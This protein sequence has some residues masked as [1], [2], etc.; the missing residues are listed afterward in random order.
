[1][2]AILFRIKDTGK[3]TL[4]MLFVFNP[5]L[6]FWSCYTLERPWLQNQIG[7]SCIP[8]GVYKCKM[9]HSP[10]FQKMTYQ[11]MS[12]PNRSA[13]RIHSGN[14]NSDIEGCI[15]LGNKLQDINKDGQLDVV[16]STATIKAFEKLLNNQDFTLTII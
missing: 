7:I 2:E 15:L 13:I 8:K 16:N 10:K 1:M 3:E 4:G 11:L 5:D 6:T 12:V 9:T 14:Y